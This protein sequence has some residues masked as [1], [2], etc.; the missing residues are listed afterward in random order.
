MKDWMSRPE[1]DEHARRIA[2]EMGPGWQPDPDHPA[3]WPGAAICGPADGLWA[4]LGISGHDGR[5]TIEG[6]YPE[7]RE[8]AVS[9][10]ITADARK[11]AGSLV[12]ADI[13]RRLFPV[14]LPQL[15]R[16]TVFN[17]NEIRDNVTRRQ[18]MT[19]VAEIFGLSTADL[20]GNG[21]FKT[22]LGIHDRP[23]TGG[24]SVTATGPGKALDLTLHDIPAETA[25]ALLRQLARMSG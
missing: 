5:L 14:Y 25:L 9:H 20:G 3:D 1:L 12:K 23:R 24:I 4:R 7:S 18:V 6:L 8:R 22:H 13:R 10:E 15:S 17:G 19:Q 11:P 16:I 21:Y 2:A